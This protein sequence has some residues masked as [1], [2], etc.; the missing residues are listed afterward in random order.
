[1]E[2]NLDASDSELECAK[3]CGGKCMCSAPSSEAVATTPSA[4]PQ[5]PKR[6][7][8]EAQ[9]ANLEKGRRI[10][11]EKRKERLAAK[12]EVS[13]LKKKVSE[14]NAEL[15]KLKKEALAKLVGETVDMK[16]KLKEAVDQV[17]KKSSGKKRKRKVESDDDSSISSISSDEEIQKQPKKKKT[18]AAAAKPAAAA[19][20]KPRIIP[21]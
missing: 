11:D 2:P 15:R 8:T 6:P 1:M 12:S 20:A 21:I 18:V 5:K 17:E 16:L 10:R 14:E 9:K 19:P 7:M 3:G 4:A 13:E